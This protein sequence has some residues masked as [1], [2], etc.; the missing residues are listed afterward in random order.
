MTR[1]NNSNTDEI[2][3]QEWKKRVEDECKARCE[4]AISSITAHYGAI[5]LYAQQQHDAARQQHD[6]MLRQLEATFDDLSDVLPIILGYFKP[7][8]IMR[9]R[10]VCK[11]WKEA[12]RKTIVPLT[13]FHL[14]SRDR[15]NGMRVM[16][17]VMPNLQ[18]ITIDSLGTGNKWSD[19]EDPD[20]PWARYY[21]DQT[22][23]DIGIISN[24]SKLRI[25]NISSLSLNGRYPL[26]FNSFPLLQKLSIKSCNHIKWDLEML[27]GLPSLKEL[28]CDHHSR[29][30]TGNINSLRVLKDTL[31]KVII[32][33]NNVEGIVVDLA[34]F[35]RLKELDLFKTDVTGDI[36]DIGDNH[37]PSLEQL[38]LP[39]GVYGG[40]GYKF[41]RISDAS[42]VVRAVYRFYKQRQML[43]MN[44]SWWLRLLADSPDCYE[45]QGWYLFLSDHD[46][47]RQHVIRDED[48]LPYYICL[49]QVGYRI[50]YRWTT[51]GGEPCEVNWLD[52][53]PDSE[54][55]DYEKYIEE[56]QVIQRQVG[57]Y[58]GFHQ[59]PTEEEYHRLVDGY[60]G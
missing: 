15:Y 1:Y 36:R 5:I 40:T 10:R 45:N 18:Q 38:T 48:T 33:C 53:E 47:P 56:L 8:H 2:N 43:K 55:S 58:R 60:N 29:Y 27:A 50:G 35:P 19:G 3:F 39:K 52:P 12:A 34:D 26:L 32:H 44:N 9:N 6:A 59:P 20:E 21:A 28:N 16:A 24:F 49:V 17:T 13:D 7:K 22:S 46:S 30:V 57:L 51:Y 11:K 4:E 37:F 25:L 41:Q 54:S 14:F 42:D 31:E 23:H